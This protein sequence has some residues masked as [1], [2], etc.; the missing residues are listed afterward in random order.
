M[1][2]KF[3]LKKLLCYF[4]FSIFVFGFGGEMVKADL[5]GTRGTVYL[6]DKYFQWK[7]NTVNNQD[8]YCIDSSSGAPNGWNLNSVLNTAVIPSDKIQPVINILA[9]SRNMDFGLDNSHKYAITQAAV[10]YTVNGTTYNGLPQY[11]Y[12]MVKTSSTYSGA[13]EYLMEAAKQDASTQPD[14]I[15]IDAVNNKLYVDGEY[16]FSQDVTLN[17]SSHVSIYEPHSTPS[18]GACIL[19]NNEC[20][21]SADIPANT[22]FKVR[23]NKPSDMSG[24]IDA[25]V[26]AES[27]EQYTKYSLETYAGPGIA[28]GKIQDMVTLT[29]QPKTLSHLRKFVGEYVNFKQIQ[30]QKIDSE[31]GQKVAGATLEIIDENN[32]SMGIFTST[33]VGEDNPKVD[34]PVGKYYLK[35]KSQPSGYYHN[36][37]QVEFNVV[38]E[39]GSLVVKDKDGNVIPDSIP[40]IQIKND[41]VKIK[42]RKVDNMG[43]PVPG[44]RIEIISYA[45]AS[46]YL[47][48]EGNLLCAITDSDGYLTQN[49]PGDKNTNNAKSS[50]EYTLGVDFGAASDIYRIREYCEVDACKPFLKPGT[51]TGE[52][53]GF[54]Q[55]FSQGF[56]VYNSGLHLFL[57]TPTLYTTYLPASGNRTNK[58]TVVNIVNNYHLNISKTDVTTGSEVAGAK[59]VIT[60]LEKPS[61]EHEIGDLKLDGVID[62][63]TSGTEPHTFLGIVPNHRYRLTELT[64]PNGYVR[65]STSVD[66]EMDVDGNVKVY[67]IETGEEI[68]SLRGTNYNLL[69]TNDYTKAVFSKTSAVTGE[70]LPGAHLKICTEKSY[71]SAVSLLGNGN[72]C[73]S[74]KEEWSWV[75]SATPNQIDRLPVGRYYMIEEIAPE[76]YVKQTNAV[77]FE[78]LE[79]G[80]VQEIQPFINEPTKVVISKKDMTS[81]EE[82]G[83]AHLQIV[84][85]DDRTV[86][87]EWDSVAGQSHE[88]D[89]LPYG[90]YIL[91][92]TL[93]ANNYQE[94]MIIDGNIVNEYEF[95][96]SED[97][98]VINID[99]YN[100]LLTD[101]PSTGISTLNLF[102]IGG[103]MIFAGYETIKIYRRKA[104]NS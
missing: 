11:L 20:T 32:N 55:S 19:Y 57:D 16:M 100:Q 104:L 1:K 62:E 78:I 25:A 72:L 69:I 33:G 27:I 48:N 75:S 10:W 42:F 38:E 86:V 5:F 83:G 35:E 92:E 102:A 54:S 40:T 52:V 84:R 49:C 22:V 6:G 85:K 97:N 59:L 45:T 41:S 88:V 61:G 98:N 13:W 2:S 51:T 82:I 8:S 77:G 74:D 79:T 46:T 31:T 23:V 26:K 21:N 43:N 91:I 76:G 50:G 64:P 18:V 80:N 66:F 44:V 90:E 37:E 15:T 81:G 58:V 39:S 95:S 68:E 47:G 103:L 3:K 67:D 96:I 17:V 65:M 89:A 24:T 29:S 53:Y 9:A 4:I 70:E 34:L 56:Q 101:V 12:N 87:E 7:Y 30:I 63:W 94:G 14:H 99:V 93:P 73:I 28:N 36:P 71:N 60:D